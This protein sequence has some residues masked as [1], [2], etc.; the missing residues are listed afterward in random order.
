MSG[1]VIDASATLPWLFE[2][3]ATPWTESLLDRIESGE[4]VLA[5]API[6]QTEQEGLPAP[7]R[8]LGFN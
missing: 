6:T 4:Q 5:R 3:E 2:N 1:F 8:I 7:Y